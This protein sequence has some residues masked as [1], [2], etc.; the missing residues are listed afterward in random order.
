MPGETVQFLALIEERKRWICIVDAK[1]INHGDLNKHSA[2]W[3][4]IDIGNE[5]SEVKLSLLRV[6]PMDGKGHSLLSREP[7]FQR[8]ISL[9]PSL[10]SLLEHTMYFLR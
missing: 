10:R 8:M 7:S 9:G 5:L 4:S 2:K 3:N 6:A 1:V